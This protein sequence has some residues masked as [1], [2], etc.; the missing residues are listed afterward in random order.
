VSGVR[1]SRSTDPKKTPDHTSAKIHPNKIAD[2]MVARRAK[3]RVAARVGLERHHRASSL[4]TL[5]HLC[6]GPDG[7]ADYSDRGENRDPGRRQKTIYKGDAIRER[8]LLRGVQVPEA[9]SDALCGNFL[10]PQR[11]L[12][13]TP[14][15]KSLSEKLI[16]NYKSF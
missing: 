6:F 13:V 7:A 15:S 10:N 12:T 5:Q 3:V 11:P 9:H 14:H 16:I 2:V 4:W 8:P 1:G